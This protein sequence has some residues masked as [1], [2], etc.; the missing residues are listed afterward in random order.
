MTSFI[1]LFLSIVLLIPVFYFFDFGLTRKGKVSVLTA[2]FIIALLGIMANSLLVLTQ[3][4]LI[5]LALI[6]L[7]VLLVNRKM[8]NVIFIADGKKEVAK[9]NAFEN[10]KDRLLNDSESNHVAQSEVSVTIDKMHL[11]SDDEK[12]AEDSYRDNLIQV[13]QQLDESDVHLPLIDENKAFEGHVDL[14]IGVENLLEESLQHSQIELPNTGMVEELHDFSNELLEIEK[15]S[16]EENTSTDLIEEKD[17]Y[18]AVEQEATGYLE[19]LFMEDIAVLDRVEPPKSE[20][21]K[22]EKMDV[23][24][25]NI[26]EQLSLN[27]EVHSSTREGDI[28][29]LASIDFPEIAKMESNQESSISMSDVEDGRNFSNII[30]AGPSEQKN[31]NA[32]VTMIS[33]ERQVIQQQLFKTMV[34]QLIVSRK[35]INK[36][37]YENMVKEYLHPELP[38]FEYY[39]FASMLINHY[40]LGKEYV[41]LQALLDGLDQK[42]QGEPILQQEIHYLQKKYVV[43]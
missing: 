5:T 14:D 24:E 9:G 8:N 19:E 13:E 16:L 27:A 12:I 11:E 1:L 21:I 32:E 10:Q 17:N 29:E 6:L 25:G 43:K 4:L 23:M 3:T 7:T 20:E 38:L 34:T 2:S 30:L 40:I 41:K 15:V 36:N 31:T 28:P 39:T 22:V 35:L 37:D 33:N 18:A 26:E 42:T